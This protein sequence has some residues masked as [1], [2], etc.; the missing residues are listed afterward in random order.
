[1]SS[2]GSGD[3][4]PTVHTLHT[5]YW[6][7]PIDDGLRHDAG[8]CRAHEHEERDVRPRVVNAPEPPGT[9]TRPAGSAHEHEK[10]AVRPRVVNA[11]GPFA[12]ALSA[13]PVN[14]AD[15]ATVGHP[16]CTPAVG[17]SGRAQRA[18]AF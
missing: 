3:P 14:N 8:E 1:M 12:G 4:S 5:V 9:A 16:S 11:T 13:V 6:A 15:S 7:Q 2:Y 18:T 17:R 10:R